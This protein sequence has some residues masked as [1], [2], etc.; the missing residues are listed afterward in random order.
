MNQ[1]IL[2]NTFYFVLLFCILV[3]SNCQQEQKKLKKETTKQNVFIDDFD[4]D[5]DNYYARLHQPRFVSHGYGIYFNNAKVKLSRVAV[6]EADSA[7]RIEYEIPP[8]YDWGNWFSIRCELA[9]EKS[10]PFS[11][12]DSALDLKDY[13]GLKLNLKVEEPS[14]GILRITIADV[15]NLGKRSDDE[16]WW[17]DFKNGVLAGPTGEWQTLTLPFNKF[18]ES[19][20]AG[21]RHNDSKLNLS[22]IIAYEINIVS[23]GKT[24][25]KGTI[26]LNSLVTY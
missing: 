18:Y 6:S 8:L 1:N 3:S 10:S 4:T 17:F 13:N 19:Y 26:V 9:T 12:I 5:H 24:H 14:N 25:L 23:K 22:K 2:R 11:G 15:V 20:G 7:L 21:T 16:L